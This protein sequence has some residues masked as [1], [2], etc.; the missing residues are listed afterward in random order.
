MRINE[1]LCCQ[2]S[3]AVRVGNE[4]TAWTES[5]K[6]VR[7]GCVLSPDLCNLYTEKILR[8]NERLDGIKIA[9]TIIS[10]ICYTDDAVLLTSENKLQELIDQVLFHSK[11]YGIETIQRKKGT[12]SY[13]NHKAFPGTKSKLT[14]PLSNKLRS[15][16]I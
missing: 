6:E 8:K 15:S 16:N 10:S 13:R 5:E 12:L 3:A 7:Q 2:Q 1:N 9:G 4:L 14:R 11:N